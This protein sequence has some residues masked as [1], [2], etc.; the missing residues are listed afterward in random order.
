MVA[1]SDI[2]ITNG[3]PANKVGIGINTVSSKSGYV[4]PS[5]VIDAFKSLQQG[6][7]VI[8]GDYQI[9]G[10]YS[11]FGGIMIFS[12]NTDSLLNNKFIE[13]IEECLKK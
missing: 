11:N 1:I 3:I 9:S 7:K 5:V 6:G 10:A 13:E 2:L 12:I 4:E 8:N